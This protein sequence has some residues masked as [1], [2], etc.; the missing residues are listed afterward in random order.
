MNL[1]ADDLIERMRDLGVIQFMYTDIDRVGTMQGPN[2]DTLADLNRRTN[3]HLTVAGGIGDIS[4]LRSLAS[5]GIESVVLGTSIYT[6][7]ID[8]RSAREEFE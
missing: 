6:G 4:H 1:T 5:I 7:V 2:L 3:A 8:F